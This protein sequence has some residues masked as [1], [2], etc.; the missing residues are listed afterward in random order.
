MVRSDLKQARIGQVSYTKYGT[1][2]IVKDYITNKK[3]LIQFQDDYKYEYYVEYAKFK[4]GQFENP[5]DKTVLGVGCIGVGKYRPTINGKITKQYSAW[6]NMLVRCYDEEKHKERETYE[7]CTVCNEWL[8]FQNFAK[9][10]DENF[11]Q[12]GDE[13]MH[14]DKDILLKGNKKYCSQYCVFVPSNINVLFTKTDKL[15]GNC[16]IGVCYREEDN[17]YFAFCNSNVIGKRKYLGSFHNELDAFREYK[18]YKESIIR[19]VADVYKG[20]IP[21]KLYEALY[22][23]EVEI[24]D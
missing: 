16:P 4:T 22:K 1:P 11:Y 2:V 17:L 5:Y 9:W 21:N 20:R 13:E 12:C 10:Y 3:V 7:K 23:Y 18:K 24:T 19:Q 15:R 6:R 8:N 14:I